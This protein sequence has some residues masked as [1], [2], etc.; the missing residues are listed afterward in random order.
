MIEWSTL[1]GLVVAAAALAAWR[2]L[3]A[4]RRRRRG[5]IAGMLVRAEPCAQRR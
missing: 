2:L 4:A 1:Q 5:S 3:R